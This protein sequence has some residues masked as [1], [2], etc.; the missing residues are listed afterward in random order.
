MTTTSTPPLATAPPPPV[1]LGRR[2]A[3]AALAI[4]LVLFT[5]YQTLVLTVVTDDVIRKGI[6]ADEYDMIWVNVAW[7][8]AV[9]Y[10][11]FGAFWLSGRIRD[12]DHAGLG[13]AVLRAGEPPLRRGRRPGQH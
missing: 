1:A 9:L 6:E 7:G 3:L 12:A 2:H 8:V 13:P 11:V 4:F 10:S 5:V